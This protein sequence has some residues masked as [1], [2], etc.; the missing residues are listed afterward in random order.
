M[1]SELQTA[2]ARPR[3]VQR[4][5]AAPLL[6]VV[7]IRL[8]KIA[9]GTKCP[10]ILQNCLTAL[11]PRNNVV[12]VQLDAY[13]RG[14]TPATTTA[15][16]TVTVEHPPTQSQGRL[17]ASGAM[18]SAWRRFWRFHLCRVRVVHERLERS[19]PPNEAA[20]VW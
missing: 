4:P 11:A 10:Q 18:S 17:A 1:V 19:R 20:V 5:G 6:A 2:V 13:R 15:C 12:H 3:S 8:T 14:R 9:V 16:E 7:F